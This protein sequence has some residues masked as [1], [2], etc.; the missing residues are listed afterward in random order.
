MRGNLLVAFPCHAVSF[1]ISGIVF[2][3]IYR[4]YLTLCEGLEGAF[5]FQNYLLSQ[6]SEH[7]GL[8]EVSERQCIA[9][10]VPCIGEI[11]VIRLVSF[12]DIIGFVIG[13]EC[14]S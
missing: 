6:L 5:A 10:E 11:G 2:P 4:N 1:A 3:S 9:D 7:H 14:V 13:Q 8:L 12:S